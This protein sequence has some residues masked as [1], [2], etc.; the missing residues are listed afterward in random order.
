M[1]EARAWLALNQNDH[2]MELVDKDKSSEADGI[3][4]EV[5]WRMQQWPQVGALLEKT[6]GDRWKKP[7]ALAPEQEAMLLR[8]G[9]AYSLADDYAGLARLR[10]H[11]GGFVDQARSAD[12]LRVALA[13]PE[14]MPALTR[15]FGKVAAATDQFAAWVERMKQKFKDEPSVSSNKLAAVGP[16]ASG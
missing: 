7:D 4:A 10:A 16:G 15:D 3:R 9:V 13:G 11:F 5:A 2:A 8:A 12:A 6:L 14:A 1:I